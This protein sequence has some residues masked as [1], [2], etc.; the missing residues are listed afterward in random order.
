[1]TIS[2][3]GITI[4]G[5]IF[6]WLFAVLNRIHIYHISEVVPAESIQSKY[7]YVVIFQYEGVV[8]RII[9]D[10]NVLSEDDTACKVL[11][12]WKNPYNFVVLNFWDFAFGV[13]IITVFISVVWLLAVHTFFEGIETFQ[14]LFHKNDKK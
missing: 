11:I 2:K 1:M 9:V 12:K 13:I 4:L 7:G 10:S 5:I 6:I 3:K 8:Y 14:L